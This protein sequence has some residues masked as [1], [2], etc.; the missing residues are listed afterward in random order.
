MTQIT[1]AAI[2]IIQKTIIA[3]GGD[4]WQQPQTLI[5]KGDAVFTPYGK[6]DEMRH[7][8]RYALYRV[9][10]T[11]N[12]S[13][14]QANGKIRFD[15]FEGDNSFFELKFGGKTS[16][17]ELS[18]AAQPYAK[19]FQWSNNFGFGIFRFADREGFVTERLTDDLVDNQLCFTVKITDPQQTVTTFWIDKVTFCIR[20]VAF[21]TDVGY[22]HR[23]YSQFAHA[24]NVAFI[25]PHRIR[26]YFEGIKWMDINWQYF[27]VNQPIEDA[28][29]E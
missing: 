3:N 20:Q 4:T 6:M 1:L 16:K 27:E 13:A 18:A 8:D 23:T 10:P 14:R 19:H 5:L 28:I 2:D 15:A 11:D 12:D 24:E 17:Q 21:I 9:F 22:H 7:F 25:Q 26:I 29:F